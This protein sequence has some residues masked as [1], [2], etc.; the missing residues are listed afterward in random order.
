MAEELKNRSEVPVELTWDLSRIY[1]TDADMEADAEK[2]K[3]LSLSMEENYKGKM[4]DAKT[5]NAC[6][7]DYRDLQR[8][9]SY[10]G[11]YT[12][13]AVS[14]DY[15]DA[16]AQEMEAKTNSLSSLLTPM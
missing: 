7:D 10:I 11:N 9:A 5:I 2:V 13:L 14:V 16:H 3:A 8:M 6:L 1:K 4:T 12:S 15:Y